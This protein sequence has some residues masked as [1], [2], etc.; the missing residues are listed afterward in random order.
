MIKPK[1][2]LSLKGISFLNTDLECKINYYGLEILPYGVI[3]KD[4]SYITV[5]LENIQ[6]SKIISSIRDF[7]IKKDPEEFIEIF[8]S[9]SNKYSV[10]CK[11]IIALKYLYDIAT[12]D[13]DFWIFG[14]SWVIEYYHERCLSYFENCPIIN[15]N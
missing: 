15:L 2:A 3:N 14:D 12:E 4:S 6:F 5:H 11:I 1:F 9:D 13:W 8:W 7:L 10:K